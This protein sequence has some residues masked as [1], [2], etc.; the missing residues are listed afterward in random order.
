MIDGTADG[1]AAVAVRPLMM[2]L[3]MVLATLDFV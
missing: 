2:V 3:V 1:I